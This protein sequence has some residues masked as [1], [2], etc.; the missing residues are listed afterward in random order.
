MGDEYGQFNRI[1][2][3]GSL[4][5]VTVG[6][7]IPLRENLIPEEHLP[8]L[9]IAWRELNTMVE[10][11]DLIYQFSKNEDALRKWDGAVRTNEGEQGMLRLYYNYYQKGR[12][13]NPDLLAAKEELQGLSRR[14]MVR[15]LFTELLSITKLFN[16]LK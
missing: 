15:P 5:E 6:E 16:L 2:S 9:R 13:G 8:K 4:P 10:R 1:L 12:G 3:F 7:D 14:M 11:G